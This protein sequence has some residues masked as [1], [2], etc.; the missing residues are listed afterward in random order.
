[1]KT[2]QLEVSSQLTPPTLRYPRDSD[3][4]ECYKNIYRE[5]FHWER[6]FED[7]E[8]HVRKRQLGGANDVYTAYLQ[9]SNPNLTFLEALPNG[10]SKA[11]KQ[12]VE[13]ALHYPGS[14]TANFF[15]RH[16]EIML[17]TAKRR[18][19]TA[20]GRR[21]DMETD[22]QSLVKDAEEVAIPSLCPRT[23][24][25][26]KERLSAREIDASEM[27]GHET[28]EEESDGDESED[29]ETAPSS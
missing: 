29:F 5:F 20:K 9:R 2:A 11:W 23:I 8:Y 4:Q 3:A 6:A 10:A 24:Q 16:D 22:L 7:Q 19:N 17:D 12:L 28:D 25:Y 1:V 26:M 14:R 15:N 21:W 18:C 27:Y 13:I